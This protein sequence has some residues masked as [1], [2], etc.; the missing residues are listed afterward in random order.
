M[1]NEQDNKQCGNDRF[2][3]NGSTNTHTDKNVFAETL[4]DGMSKVFAG[5]KALIAAILLGFCV[6]GCDKEL[7]TADKIETVSKLAGT[8][9]AMVVNMT[10]ID[11][12]SKTVILDIMDKVSKSIPQKDQTFSEAW[13]PIAKEYVGKLVEENKINEAQGGLILSGFAIT[14]DG[15]DYVFNVKYPKAREYKELVD[16]AVRGFVD[17]YKSVTVSAN[18]KGGSAAPDY[19]KDA[20]DYLKKKSGL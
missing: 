5:A 17:G 16:A 2:N 6:I 9:A 12:Q 8:S 19:D 11:E 1:N 7:P 18:T 10:K 14:C 15:L 4:K 20:F 3:E 13:N